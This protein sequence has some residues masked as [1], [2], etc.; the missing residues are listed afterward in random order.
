MGK[1]WGI[2]SL[3]SLELGSTSVLDPSDPSL[4]TVASACCP[5]PTQMKKAQLPGLV[6]LGAL[7]SDPGPLTPASSQV[8]VR[9][10]QDKSKRTAPE[11]PVSG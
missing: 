4:A 7:T 10:V 2:F 5:P 6:L 3:A 9:T 1:A 11:K 8:G